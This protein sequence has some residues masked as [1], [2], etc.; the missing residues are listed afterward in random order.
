M[1][2]EKSDRGSFHGT[3][4]AFTWRDWGKLI[5]EVLDVVFLRVPKKPCGLRVYT[6]FVVVP[7]VY[8]HTIP[9]CR[10]LH[11]VFCLW[12]SVLQVINH[13]TIATAM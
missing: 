3:V 1:N 2:S 6:A 12:I 8:A 7:N 4:S 5:S 9:H 13:V 10:M 11:A